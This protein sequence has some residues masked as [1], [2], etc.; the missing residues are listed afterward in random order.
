MENTNTTQR[1]TCK[2]CG[3]DAYYR[4]ITTSAGPANAISRTGKGVYCRTHGQ[5]AATKALPGWKVRRDAKIAKSS[6]SH[7]A[8]YRNYLATKEGN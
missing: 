6:A 4:I 2:V 5:E 8:W 3:E 7:A 1:P